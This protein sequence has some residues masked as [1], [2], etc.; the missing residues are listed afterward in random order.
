MGKEVKVPDIGDFRNVPIIELL[1]KEGD[2]LKLDQPLI[3]L[4][5]D[6]ATLEVPA[7]EAGRV[8]RVLVKLGER[9]SE[10]SPILI[11]AAP[12]ESTES[13]SPDPV[14]VP[15]ATPGA[16]PV[17]LPVE[18]KWVSAPVVAPPVSTIPLSVPRMTPA[19]EEALQTA[20]ASPTVRRFAREL[21]VDL[22]QV[23]GSGPHQRI[24]R[25]DIQ[26]FVKAALQ[27]SPAQ[28][29]GWSLGD[30]PAW[31]MVDFAKY[32]PVETRPL[33]RIKKLSGGYLHRNWLMIPHVTNH[34]EVDITELEEFRQDLNREA[35]PEF[36]KI[37]LLTLVLKA[38][39]AVLPGFPE[40]NASLQGDALILKQYIHL[41]FAADTASGLMVPVVRDVPSKGIRSIASEVAELAA[42][43]REGRLA[44]EEMQG[45]TFSVSSLGGIGG[46]F[47]TPIINAPEVAILGLGRALQKP[48]WCA[49]TVAGRW[50][51]PLSLS[52]DHRVIDG[53]GAARFN[54]ALR[55][56][57]ADIRR[58]LV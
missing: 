13:P 49:G 40:F 27:S 33:G 35:G 23:A 30:L 45:G 22:G 48:V 37:T 58:I 12:G 29:G 31:P 15:V 56:I 55:Q 42:R 43:A 47:F 5:S 46:S 19:G 50:M 54:E 1:V 51:L 53:A 25:E 57:L 36:P 39:A 16:D 10:G 4:E 34:E 2:L 52:Y 17:T 3:T 32:G 14:P 41:G 9:V 18:E 11:L 21:G 38:L 26:R 7:P 24:L 44:P 28:G 6:K 8:E 20:H